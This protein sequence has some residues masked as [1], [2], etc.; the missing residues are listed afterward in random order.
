MYGAKKLLT[1]SEVADLL[2]LAAQHVKAAA[3]ALDTAAC[4]APGDTVTRI[5]AIPG[6]SHIDTGLALRLTDLADAIQAEFEAIKAPV[7]EDA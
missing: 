6:Q 5:E 4:G 3:N 2:W 7:G 1:P